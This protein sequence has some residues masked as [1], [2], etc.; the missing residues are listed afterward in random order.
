MF[1]V[2]PLGGGATTETNSIKPPRLNSSEL[3]SQSNITLTTIYMQLI[4]NVVTLLMLLVLIVFVNL[5]YKQN[6]LSHPKIRKF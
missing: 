6:V 3:R 2:K 1:H 5:Y 4:L